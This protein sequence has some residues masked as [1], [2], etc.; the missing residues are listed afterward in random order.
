MNSIEEWRDH[1]DSKSAI[2]DPV[3]L[4]GYCIGGVPISVGQYFAAVINPVIDRLDLR[5]EHRVLDIGCG[6][7]LTLAE[8]EKQV[9]EAI[10]T[11]L[12]GSLLQC[13]KGEA[14]T[15]TCA[16]HELPFEGEQFDRILMFSVAIYFPSF[17][18]LK[19]VIEKA[20]SLLRKDGLFLIGDLNL[21]VRPNGSQYLWYEREPLLDYLDGLGV[22]YSLLA[23]N[24]L[25]RKLNRRWDVVLRKD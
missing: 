7:G 17:D 10:G 21:G 1:W 2:A 18:Y 15:Y 24:K 13:Y 19:K 23:Q 4:N 6:S 12:S 8:I 9:A 25:K 22:A 20:L 5:P 14:R 11:D 3:V 16:A